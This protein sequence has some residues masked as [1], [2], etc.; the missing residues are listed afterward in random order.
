MTSGWVV[1][2]LA[3]ATTAPLADPGCEVTDAGYA[4]DPADPGH[5]LHHAMLMMAFAMRKEVQILAEGCAF[6]KPRIIAVSI[7]E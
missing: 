3:V 6:G 7:R 5:Q 2:S 4:T 1:D